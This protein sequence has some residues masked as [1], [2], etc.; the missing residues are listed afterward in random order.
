MPDKLIPR[1]EAVLAEHG[2]GGDGSHDL[3][4]ARRV[5]ATALA[6]AEREGQG[7]RQVLVAAAYLHDLVNLPKTH[8]ERHTASTRS[9]EAAA[10]L[11]AEL[12]LAPKR[13]AEICHAILAHSFSAGVAPDTV[14]A[15][16]LQ[17]A[18]R[19]EALGAI[20]IARTFYVSG[21][22]GVALFDGEDPFAA[23]RDLDDGAFAL[24]HFET[25]LLRL[26]DMMQTE[27]GRTLARERAD[28][29]R[30]YLDQLRREL[31]V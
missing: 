3:H 10:P 17:D 1:L 18:D 26:P 27:G 2:T 12:G 29:M 22:N 19:L 15:R 31:A 9:A 13:I 5:R 8:P 4:H 7:D 6:I 14:E 24:D 25:K 30:R 23:T 11:L 28:F 21:Q 16:I 20:G